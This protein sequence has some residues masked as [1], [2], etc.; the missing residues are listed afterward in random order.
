MGFWIGAAII[1]AI[2]AV[3]VRR[4]MQMKALAV[5]GILGRAQVVQKTRRRTSAGHQT[6]GYIK[7]RFDTPKGESLTNRIAVSEQV[8]SEYSDGDP[9][10]IVYLEDRPTTNAARYMVNL[11]R[12][13]LKLPPL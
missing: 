6:A 1:L 9:I 2:V 12:K 10:D 8:Y 11:S 4:G 3:L 5:Q 7:Y 13:A